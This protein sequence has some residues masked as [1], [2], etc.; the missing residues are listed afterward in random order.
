MPR[1]SWRWRTLSAGLL[2]LLLG[3]HLL[4]ILLDHGFLHGLLLADFLHAPLNIRRRVPPAW[5]SQRAR[6]NS[7]QQP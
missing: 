6:R 5:K 3:H 1:Q 2:G 4:L 7:G